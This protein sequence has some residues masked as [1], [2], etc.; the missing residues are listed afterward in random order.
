MQEIRNRL[1]NV[2]FRRDTKI[3][4]A[5]IVIS[6]RQGSTGAKIRI[7]QPHRGAAPEDE[8]SNFIRSLHATIETICCILLV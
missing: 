7:S 4:K 6:G 2:R 8:F 1:E 3:A 5:L